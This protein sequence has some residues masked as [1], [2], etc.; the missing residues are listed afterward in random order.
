MKK[1][2]IY[3]KERAQTTTSVS[4]SKLNRKKNIFI[5]Y[6]L[7]DVGRTSRNFVREGVSRGEQKVRLGILL[8]VSLF[9]QL[10]LEMSC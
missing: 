1:K 6:L 5:Y 10:V 9:D 8:D 7:G 3:N 4:T 2:N